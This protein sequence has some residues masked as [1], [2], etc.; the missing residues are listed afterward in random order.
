MGLTK[1]DHTICGP[2][3]KIAPVPEQI[4]LLNTEFK[5]LFP[6]KMPAGLPPARITD[7]HITL[8]PNS[9]APAQRLYRLSPLQDKELQKQLQELQEAGF[10]EPATSEY[11]SGILFV[12]K[13]S[14][15]LRMCVD[16]RPLNA[17]TVV[18]QYPLPRIEELIDQVEST[19][20]FFSKLDLHSGFHQIRVVPED[21]P[22]TAFKTKYGT[23]QYRVMPFGLCNAPATFQRTMDLVFGSLRQFVGVYMDDVLVFSNTLEEHLD[24]FRI[25]YRKLTKKLLYANPEKCTFAK[26]EVAYYGFIVGSAG[27]RAQPEKLAIV[28]A[29]PRHQ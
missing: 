16:Y 19:A 27:V 3:C 20:K 17:L 26:P 9:R 14:G 23:F 12:T 10:I 11:G 1:I 5:S 24:Y 15:K 22:K 2:P 25:V 6:E 8:K 13:A 7:H 28:H 4:L 18:D 21:I 29:W